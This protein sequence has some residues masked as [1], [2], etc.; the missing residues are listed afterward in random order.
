MLEIEHLKEKLESTVKN[1]ELITDEKDKHITSLQ[2]TLTIKTKLCVK[3]INENTRLKKDNEELS[4]TC[5]YKGR[6]I[7]NENQ[8]RMTED[9][10]NERGSWSQVEGKKRRE[11]KS[12][13]SWNI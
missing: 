13:A 11:T 8:L 9:Q 2:K 3:I 1:H 4:Q 6:N 5:H 7:N 10:N 12:I